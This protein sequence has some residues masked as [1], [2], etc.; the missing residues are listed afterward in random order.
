MSYEKNKSKSIK[1]TTTT[2]TTTTKSTKGI[3][4]IIEESIGRT[5]FS[6]LTKEFTKKTTNR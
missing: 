1:K 4:E 6:L 5:L 2:T 3:G